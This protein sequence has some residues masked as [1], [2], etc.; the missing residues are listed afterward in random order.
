M[1]IWGGGGNIDGYAL[2]NYGYTPYIDGYTL[3][4]DGYMAKSKIDFLQAKLTLTSTRIL[5]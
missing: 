4:I 1:P 2:Y 3:Y 5:V